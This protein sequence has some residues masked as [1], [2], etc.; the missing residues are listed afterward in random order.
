[1]DELKFLRSMTLLR[2]ISACIEVTAVYLMW[3]CTRVEQAVRLNAALGAVGPIIFTLVSL[4][5]VWGLAGKVPTGKLFM[6]GAGVLLVLWG[7]H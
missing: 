6:V 1:V 7:T 3:R 5:G 2:L 4:I